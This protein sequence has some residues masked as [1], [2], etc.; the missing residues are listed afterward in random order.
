MRGAHF[1]HN[2]TRRVWC[3]ACAWRMLHTTPSIFARLHRANNLMCCVGNA[4]GAFPTQ[5]KNQASAAG[6]TMFRSKP[7]D[8]QSGGYVSC[9]YHTRAL[10]GD[11]SVYGRGDRKG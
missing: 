2:K 4:L 5:H 8:I 11:S 1:S 6:A 10:H 7:Q 3:G 9:P